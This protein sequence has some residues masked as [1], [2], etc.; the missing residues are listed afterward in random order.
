[1]GGAPVGVPGYR[2]LCRGP[3]PGGGADL[4]RRGAATLITTDPLRLGS[5]GSPLALVQAEIVRR[6]IL[7]RFPERE[8]EVVVVRTQGDRD[9]SSLMD[10]G[11]MG[12][13]AVELETALRQGD[14]DVAVHSAKDL[15]FT[16]A[17]GLELA[18]FLPRA[19]P[20]D[21]LVRARR[22]VVPPGEGFTIATGSPRRR[23][24]LAQAWP[25]VSFVD[26]RGNVDTRLRKLAAGAADAL[27]LAAAGLRRLGLEPEGEE[28]IPFHWCVP[29]PG[30]GAI[31]VQGRVDDPLTADVRWL[32]H[33]ATSLAVQAE[34]E[35]AAGLGASC[36]LPFGVHVRFQG[37]VTQLDA[38]LH[39][40]E[41]LHRVSSRAAAGDPMEA[42][43]LALADLRDRGAIAVHGG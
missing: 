42:V 7:E 17:D 29:S 41:R 26:I 1:M 24:Q 6:A 34:R 21:V 22:S 19:D 14:V 37:G 31:V 13:F 33:F 18:A 43:G 28:E 38:A 4:A 32:N 3:G 16:E 27:C 25:G 10:I 2:G 39:D 15:A 35:M 30:Q 40:G 8:V 20:H 23:A 11:G 9:R 36:S 5:R 12:V